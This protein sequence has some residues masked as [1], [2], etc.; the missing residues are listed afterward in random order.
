ML[1]FLYGMVAIYV[2]AAS[3]ATIYLL[4]KGFSLFE[5][6][7]HGIVLPLA[8]GGYL[9]QLITGRNNPFAG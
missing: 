3:M 4:L 9:Y 6:I 8:I 7:A 2:I 1:R 5:A